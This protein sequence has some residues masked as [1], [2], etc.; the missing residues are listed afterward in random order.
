M[1]S[2]HASCALGI[3]ILN[4][5]RIMQ[6]GGLFSRKTEVGFDGLSGCYATEG[7]LDGLLIKSVMIFYILPVR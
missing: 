4:H 3:N 6:S 1:S 2:I 5:R 7:V